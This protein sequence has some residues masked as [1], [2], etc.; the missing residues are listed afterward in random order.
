MGGRRGSLR[1]RITLAITLSMS[2]VL[3][4]F[5]IVSYYIIQKSI[6]SSLNKRL[7]LARLIRNNID[8]IIEDNINRLYDISLSGSVNLDDNDFGPEREALTTAYKYSIF[9]DGIFLLDKGGNV[10]LTYPE[11]I[12][13]K[14][15]NLL[16]IEPISRI[17]ATG[18]PVVSNI[19]T[20]E[21]TK[22]KVL[23]VLVPLKDKN[24]NYVGVAGGEIDPT[25][26][27][28]TH[29]L[30]LIDIGENTF[31]DIIDSNGVVISSSKPARSLTYCDYNKFF[32][33]VISSKKECVAT[34][35][36]CHDSGKKERSTNVLT[37]TP[38]ELAPWGVSIQEPKEDIFAPALQLRKTFI[39]L[40]VIFVGTAFL[41]AMGI[42]RSIVNPI[43]ELT[44]ATNQIAKGELS[45]P[46]AQHGTDEIGILSQSFDVMRIK[47]AESLE[48][49]KRYSAELEKR[50]LD[51]TK[52]IRQA[53]QKVQTLL[54]QVITSQEDE[55]KRIARELHDEILQDISVLLIKLDMCKM[56]PERIDDN[57][58]EEMKQL[59]EKII[60]DI[61]DI[62]KNLRPSILDDL[63]LDAAIKWLLDKHL[64]EKG[65]NYFLNMKT[66]PNKRFD[67]Q[68][69]ITLFRI[70]QE[71]IINIAKHAE[72]NN[73]FV[74]IKT[75]D[76]LI[77]VDIEDDGKGFDVHS[78]LKSTSGKEKGLG[79]L[80]MKE[81]A[82]ILDGKLQIC[83]ILGVGTR[84]NVKLPLKP[85]RSEN[86]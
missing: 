82:S 35:H 59:V 57:R 61:H 51:R 24:G 27:I 36:Q 52:K 22:R 70:I 48:N 32:S 33:T 8:S 7:A 23:F 6:E 74:V 76:T 38:L 15:L 66:V 31:I 34:C 60:D 69:E 2:I 68:V 37:F 58:I 63:G 42:N 10:L 11:K 19:Y 86:V 55:R 77:N 14:N 43:K 21:T 13:E 16:S 18:K 54:K 9:T 4:S 39:A 78:I 3:L 5:G 44:K 71:S 41:L 29:M 72:A 65:I 62:I 67:S 80:G 12:E 84:V 53:Q 79:L 56:Y 85:A 50:V 73:V 81:R 28:L 26:P 1:K 30:K 45:K 25:N 47:L 75:T 83:S 64:S 46:I 49:L 17:I 20:T 40:G